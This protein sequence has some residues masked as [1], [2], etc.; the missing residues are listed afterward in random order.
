MRHCSLFIYCPHWQTNTWKRWMVELEPCRI[1]E[2]VAP[3]ETV[4][5]YHVNNADLKYSHIA[6]RCM[7]SNILTCAH[8]QSKTLSFKRSMGGFKH[9]CTCWR[10]CMLYFNCR[11]IC[12]LCNKKVITTYPVLYHPH[13]NMSVLVWYQS[14]ECVSVS[15]ICRAMS[16]AVRCTVLKVYELRAT[17]VELKNIIDSM[18]SS[19]FPPL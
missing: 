18:A 9:P 11:V 4:R 15:A 14:V 5:W 3:S 12:V 7:S 8:C 13:F 6:A 10:L 1:M 17:L 16:A 19:M 2:N